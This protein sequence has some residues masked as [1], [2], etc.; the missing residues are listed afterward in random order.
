[1]T[2]TA[3]GGP[4]APVLIGRCSECGQPFR[5]DLEPDTPCPAGVSWQVA[6]TFARWRGY[7]TWHGCRTGVRCPEGENGLPACGDWECEGH[8]R[9][10]IRY[11][12]LRS[13]YKPGVSCNAATC[14]TARSTTCTCSCRGREHGSAWRITSGR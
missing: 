13:T 6:T 11:R 10:E 14:G 3:A 8:E 1:M 7:Q 2:V 12:V 5:A 4:L 9:T